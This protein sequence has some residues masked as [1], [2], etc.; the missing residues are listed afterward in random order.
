MVAS[1]WL[2]ADTSADAHAAQLAV[3]RRIGTTGRAGMLLEM[4]ETARQ[5]ARAGA[6]LRHPEYSAAQLEEEIK[7][8]FLGEQMYRQVY[9]T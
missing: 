4:N 5:L 3:L 9:R 1:A 8:A 7:K 2:P 6:R